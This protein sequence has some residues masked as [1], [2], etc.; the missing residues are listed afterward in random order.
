MKTSN[1][2][3]LSSHSNIEKKKKPT[4]VPTKPP[5]SSLQACQF[6]PLTCRVTRDTCSVVSLSSS[7]GHRAAAPQGQ[8]PVSFP[9]QQ[10]SGFY[11]F[12]FSRPHLLLALANKNWPKSRNHKLPS[13]SRRKAGALVMWNQQQEVMR[14]PRR[15]RVAVAEMTDGPLPGDSPERTCSSLCK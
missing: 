14:T 7:W 5:T 6:V 8:I 9:L 3:I 1:I 4:L 12:P 2:K 15:W 10:P 13:K 11:L